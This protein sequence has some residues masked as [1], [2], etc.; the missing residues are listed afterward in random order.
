MKRTIHHEADAV[1][2]VMELELSSSDLSRPHYNLDRDEVV[3]ILEGR[4]RIQ[5]ADQYI[6]LDSFDQEFPKWHL[7]KAGVAHTISSEATMSVIL[8]VIGGQFFDGACV[9][10]ESL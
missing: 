2:N 7:I 1:L 8:E 6:I 5:F 9:N 4:I 3:F 10:L